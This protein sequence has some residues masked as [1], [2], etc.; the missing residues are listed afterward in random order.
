MAPSEEINIP[1]KPPMVMV[2]RIVRTEGPVTVTAFRVKGDNVFTE[3][4]FLAEPG[5]MENM[6]QTAAAGAGVLARENG[7]AP[8]TGFI[9][10][11]KDLKIF[12]LPAVGEEM[13]TT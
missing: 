10:A 6:A 13:E 7:Q 11:I 2:D 8:R 5:I 3:N 4:G 9:G 12:R 1:Q